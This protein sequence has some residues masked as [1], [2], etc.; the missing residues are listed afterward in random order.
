MQDGIKG[1]LN[2]LECGQNCVI[3]SVCLCEPFDSK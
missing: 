1:S 2:Y 3:S